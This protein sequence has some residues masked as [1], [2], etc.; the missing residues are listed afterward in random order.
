MKLSEVGKNKEDIVNLYETYFYETFKRFDFIAESGHESYLVDEAGREYL[1]FM[2][3]IAVNSAG[4]CNKKVVEAIKNQCE[5]LIHAS[6]YCY[7]IPQAMLAELICKSIEFEKIY[8]QNSGAEAN[9]VMIKLA[10]NYGKDN[11]GPNRY[12][13]VTALNSFHGRTLATLAATGQPN[14][15]IQHNYDP[16]I[17]GISYAEYNNLKAFE[18]A[19]DEDTIAVMVEPIQGEGGVIPA[20]KEFLQGLRKLCDERD[21]LL[22]F[23]EVQTGWGRTGSLMAFM[24]YGVKPDCVSMAKAMGGGMPIG[25]MCTSAKL[26]LTFGPGAHGSTYAGN[27]VCCA[28]SYAQIKEVIDNNLSDNSAKMGEYFRGILAKLPHVKEVR[29]NGLMI[30]VEFDKDI[31]TDVKYISADNGLLMTAVRPS[32]IRLVPP[33]NVTKEECDKAFEIIDKVVKE[34]V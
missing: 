25:A 29:G 1:E 5:D 23:D 32:V 28:A 24:G 9:E 18:D 11:Y 3:G 14:T 19:C 15:A 17:P 27:P 4:H 13:I 33:L 20:T 26:A 22:L 7:T 6:N 21:M 16:F 2:A 10:R 30:G 34:L 12:K 31:A 8:L